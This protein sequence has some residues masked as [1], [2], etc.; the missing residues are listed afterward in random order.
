MHPERNP[1]VLNLHIRK[2]KKISKYVFQK[3][4]VRQQMKPNQ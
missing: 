3:V 1:I 4:R 2:A